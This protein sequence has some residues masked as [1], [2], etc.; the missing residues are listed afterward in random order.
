M[1]LSP[2][3]LQVKNQDD[4]RENKPV[5]HKRYETVRLD[6]AQKIPYAQKTDDCRAGDSNQEDRPLNRDRHQRGVPEG[7][8]EAPT[9]Q[10]PCTNDHGR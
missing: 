8:E 10:D 4:G 6:V 5:D 2:G 1:Y 7:L 3:V 9:F